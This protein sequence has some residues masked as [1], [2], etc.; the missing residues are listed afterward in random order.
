MMTCDFVDMSKRVKHAVNVNLENVDM[1][2]GKSFNAIFPDAGYVD[3][4]NHNIWLNY[5]WYLFRAKGR[6]ATDVQLCPGASV[7]CAKGR[8]NPT[9][10][11]L[12]QDHLRG[13]VIVNM[14]GICQ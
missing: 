6:T 14:Q 7:L 3:I 2:P 9:N 4:E 10:F 8:M 12:P 13:S 5:H 11:A 1:V